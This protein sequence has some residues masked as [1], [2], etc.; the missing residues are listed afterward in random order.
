MHTKFDICFVSFFFFFLYLN[1]HQLTRKTQ[2][3]SKQ[4]VLFYAETFNKPKSEVSKVLNVLFILNKNNNYLMGTIY[5][6]LHYN[7]DDIAKSISHQQ[8]FKYHKLYKPIS[9]IS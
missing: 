7:D 1:Y 9:L 5:C 8:L 3:K 2:S 6:R 4:Y